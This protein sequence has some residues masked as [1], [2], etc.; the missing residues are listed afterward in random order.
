MFP[1]LNQFRFSDSFKFLSVVQ[2]LPA[3]YQEDTAFS[4]QTRMPVADL[5]RGRLRFDAFYREI[6]ANYMGHGVAQSSDSWQPLP[7]GLSLRSETN[8]GIT[9]FFRLARVQ[10]GRTFFHFL[11]GGGSS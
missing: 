2:R 1:K 8:Y 6:S 5:W 10:P 3:F 9:L 7:A 11:F 4:T